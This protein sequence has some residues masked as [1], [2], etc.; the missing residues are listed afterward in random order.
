MPLKTFTPTP[1]ITELI[2]LLSL[3]L[4]KKLPGEKAHNIMAPSIRNYA[5]KKADPS[6]ARK[7]GVLLLLYPREEQL[8][9]G[10]IRR[11]TGG[12]NHS[13]QMSFPG[14][15]YELSDT[16]LIHTA[17]RETQEELGIPIEQVKVLGCLTHLFIPV[18]NFHVAPVVGILPHPPE[19]IPNPFEV[20]QFVE[21][22]LN[23][24]FHPN[25]ISNQEIIKN[26]YRIQTPYYNALGNKVWGATAMILSEL[27]QVC[28]QS[29]L[30]SFS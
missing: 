25:N 2:D 27:H 12:H 18:S 5:L 10:L 15:K 7:S 6:K 20:D 9:I 22:P 14:G 24:L 1:S 30:I 26:G 11:S 23:V 28:S 17:L 8:N 21:I 13:G 16:S 19:V 4:Q 29:G 3:E